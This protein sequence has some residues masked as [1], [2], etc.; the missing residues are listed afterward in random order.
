MTQEIQ[1]SSFVL[2]DDQSPPK[3]QT[4]FCFRVGK[5]KLQPPRELSGL[6]ESRLSL[7]ISNFASHIIRID[8]LRTEI[9]YSNRYKTPYKAWSIVMTR[10]LRTR[11]L[12]GAT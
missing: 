2:L 5:I 10:R 11:L 9:T 6:P 3:P 7:M 8:A 12:I 1:T 4:E